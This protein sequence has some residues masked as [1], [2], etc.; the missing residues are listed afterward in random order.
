MRYKQLFLL[1]A[2]V[3]LLAAALP[4][5]AQEWTGK[6]RLQGEVRDEQG[7]PIEGAKITLRS[8]TDRVDPAKDGP[9][10]VT[11]NKAGKWAA[12]GLAGGPWGVLIEKEGYI[13]SEGQTSVNEY[14]VAQP[15]NRTLK[16][17]PKEVQQKAAE[18]SG[19]AKAKV[20]FE[21]GNAA[22]QA[23]QWAAARAK[24]EEGLGLLEQKDPAVHVSVLRAIAETYSQEGN[25][26]KAIET[27]KQALEVDPNDV[28]SLQIISTLLVNA[29]KEKEAE[30]YMA[31][32]PAGT[33]IDP[34]SMLNV[35]IKLY[36]EK[37]YN[38]ALE[39]F[40]K[41]VLDNPDLANAYYYRGLTFLA[42]NKS[43]EAKAD[44]QKLLEID[45][46]NPNAADVR[47]FLKSL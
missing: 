6:G 12:L 14:A 25:T 34:N 37:D 23:G 39:R 3:A 33:K 8:G 29:G 20:A 2:V 47:E 46:N 1:F 28:A 16:V 44:F 22:L 38:G 4:L 11:T 21:Q 35:G 45:P 10:P 32:L 31:K 40:N 19:N 13:P 9:K 15:I 27:L 43:A 42:L 7:K 18:A 17:I 26:D 30:V 5:S 24:F 41:V 36:N